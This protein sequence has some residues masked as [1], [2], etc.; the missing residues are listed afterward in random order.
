[1]APGYGYYG[2]PS[3]VN[4]AC[5]LFLS[6]DP[7]PS[8]TTCYSGNFRLSFG[9]PCGFLPGGSCLKS[10]LPAILRFSTFPGTF[11]VLR[12]VISIENFPRLT[13][14]SAFTSNFTT[15]RTLS[16]SFSAGRA[17][18]YRN[19]R[20]VRASSATCLPELLITVLPLDFHSW[21][22]CGFCSW[23]LF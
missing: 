20:S 22:P 13:S 17:I 9:F 4:A 5:A 15:S 23:I 2:W 3:D 6:T 14:R 7:K 12:P 16:A 10:V 8:I 18:Y 19:S 1:M 21:S 11:T